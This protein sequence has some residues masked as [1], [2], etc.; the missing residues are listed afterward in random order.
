MAAPRAREQH[1]QPS[2]E[3][4][5]PSASRRPLR[6]RLV[7]L[8]VFLLCLAPAVALGAQTLFGTVGAD[9]VEALHHATGIWAIRFL[10]LTLLVTPLRRL[11]GWNWLQKYR[12]MLG[13]FAFFY[14]TLHL[15]VYLV[16]DQGLYVDGIVE[17]VLERPY[18]TLGMV[19]WLLLVPLAVT[20]TGGWVRRLGKRWQKLHRLVYVVAGAAAVHYLL[21]VKKDVTLP[22]VY[23]SLFVGLFAIRGWLASRARRR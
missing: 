11:L 1:G 19:A 16:L 22:L 5:E 13:L 14:A 8:A 12:R 9:P 6:P 3:R 15:L 18:I 17:D 4:R 2:A 23:L 10:V 21:A 20:S 7:R